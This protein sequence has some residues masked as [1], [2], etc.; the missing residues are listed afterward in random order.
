MLLK[1][2]S[3]ILQHQP[4]YQNILSLDF[5]NSKM[6][7][8]NTKIY[9]DENTSSNVIYL[10]YW[11]VQI[12]LMGDASIATEQDI[13]EKYNLKNIDILKVG[14]HGSKTSSDSSFIDSITP[15]YSVIS[16]GRNNRYNHPNKEVLDNLDKSI[17]YRTDINGTIK[18]IINKNR[19]DIITYDP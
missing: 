12:L 13:L 9:D 7:F 5:A 14:H 2:F 16:V 18:F 19:L 11:G 1:L 17:I 10:N 3:K 15:K 4:S 6:Y 8:L